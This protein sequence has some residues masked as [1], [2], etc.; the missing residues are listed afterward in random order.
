MER[1]GFHGGGRHRGRGRISE[2]LWDLLRA[3]E[4]SRG[5]RASGGEVRRGRQGDGGR[6]EF[7]EGLRWFE[8]RSGRPGKPA[9]APV[10]PVAPVSVAAVARCPGCGEEGGASGFGHRRQMERYR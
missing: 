7:A 4:P 6:D 3:W 9:F 5:R 8:Q 1:T 10:A 2:A